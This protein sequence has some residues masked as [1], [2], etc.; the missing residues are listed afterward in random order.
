MANLRQ[1]A[2]ALAGNKILG[3]F[4]FWIAAMVVL[5]TLLPPA[6]AFAN[7]LN[8][9]SVA[10]IGLLFFMHG[11]K[12]SR[13]ALLGGLSNWRLHLLVFFSTFVLFPILGEAMRLLPRSLLSEETL[14][15]F[16]YLC[17][18]PAT[19]QSAIAFTSIA[20][21]NVAAAVCSASASTLIGVVVSPMLASL[22]L[23]AQGETDPLDSILKV[24]AQLLAPF[25]VG[26]MSRPL[27]GKWM[28]RRA[29]RVNI[30][31]QSCILLIVY[32]A[33]GAAVNEGLWSRYPAGQL[34]A[35]MVFSCVLL[36][37]VMSFNLLASRAL[38]FE[39]ADRVAIVFCG[40]KKSLANGVPMA[41]V[42]F[43]A[44]QVGPIL[45]PLMIFHQ[46][47]LMV[48]GHLAQRWA[49]DAPD[50]PGPSEETDASGRG[51]KAAPESASAKAG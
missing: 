39:R 4:T 49:N 28:A 35:A 33:F 45:L 21:G 48:C 26:H 20:K 15:G 40:S 8:L 22:M 31:D 29:R 30:V 17:V 3:S 27:T 46:I 43:P 41:N 16:V 23:S 34:I 11:A 7:S 50:G 18:L 24:A 25:F 51:A 10:A 37:I 47:Q 5:A 13:R 38:G 1:T 14:R 19:V 44:A 12:L 32:S 2:A 36:A 6:G 9:V 42:L